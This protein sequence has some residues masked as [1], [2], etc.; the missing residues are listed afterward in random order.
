VAAYF[1]PWFIVPYVATNNND[2]E[3]AQIVQLYQR[4]DTL[5]RLNAAKHCADLK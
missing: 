2:A 3:K 1:G 5:I 4:R